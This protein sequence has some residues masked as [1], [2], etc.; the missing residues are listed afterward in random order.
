MSLLVNMSTNF[1]HPVIG[2]SLDYEE[3]GGYSKMPWYALRENYFSSVASLGAIPIGLPHELAL[4]NAYLG[5][6]DGLI[7]TGGAFDVSPALY[8][9]TTTHETVVTKDKRTQFEFAM[10]KGALER[11]MPI[12]GICGGQQLLNVVLGGTLIQH[13]PDSIENAL[14]HEQ[15]NLRTEPGHSI[16]IAKGSLLH[17]ITGKEVMHVN[18]AHHQAVDKPAPGVT[19]T[20]ASTDG[21]I[22]AI[23]YP[24]HPFCL[25]V[26]WHPE[27][28]VDGGDNDIFIAFVKAAADYGG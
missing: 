12:L 14:E 9:D 8:G 26:Q 18:T 4:V 1:A 10:V 24:A 7:I 25:G 23:E 13:I 11:K 16:A 28:H 17:S 19:I 20:A 15:K 5:M 27:Y 21:V 2:Y 6:L 3:S 22:E